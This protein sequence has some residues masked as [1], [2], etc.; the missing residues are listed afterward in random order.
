MDFD[1]SRLYLPGDDI[2]SIDWR[3]TARSGTAH[4][5]VYREERERPVFVVVDFCASMFF[6]TRVAFKSVIAAQTAATL[7]WAAAA[8][9]DRVGAVIFAEDEHHEMRPAAGR[10]GVLRVLRGLAR[11]SVS[12][13]AVAAAAPLAQALLRVRRVARPGSLIF[14]CSDFYTLDEDAVRHLRR[15]SQHNE[16]VACWIFDPLEAQAPP[17]GRYAVTDG[18]TR[19]LVA[20]TGAAAR[21]AFTAGFDGRRQ[22]LQVL[23]REGGVRLVP[24]ATDANVA[25][26]LQ[27][28]LSSAGARAGR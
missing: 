10:R 6:G 5:K 19:V 11:A 23:A 1:E 24:I 4:T 21:R 12:S 27:R 9:A 13:G 8:N 22:R 26:C 20:T 7:A 18:V 2:R 14:V 16:M 25:E 3:V 17:P 28:G 15:L